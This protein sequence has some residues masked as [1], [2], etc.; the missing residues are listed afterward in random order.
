MTVL[1][2]ALLKK[3]ESPDKNLDKS[4]GEEVFVGDYLQVCSLTL[5]QLK[6]FQY[7]KIFKGIAL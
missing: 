2:L 7:S 6:F 4:L 5:T 1:A 3:K